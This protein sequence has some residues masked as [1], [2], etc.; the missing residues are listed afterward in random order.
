[1]KLNTDG[2]KPGSMD[3]TPRSVVVVGLWLALAAL[4]GWLIVNGKGVSGF[5]SM[6]GLAVLLVATGRTMRKPGTTATRA[7]GTGLIS[8]ALVLVLLY[9]GAIVLV[10]ATWRGP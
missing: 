10:L 7:V 6:V 5:W 1:M 8:G 9:V 4:L 3:I 2:T